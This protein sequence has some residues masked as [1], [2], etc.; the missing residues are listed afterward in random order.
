MINRQSRE[1]IVARL[2]P[3]SGAGIWE[4]GP[5]LGALTQLLVDSGASVRL[6][7]VD[8]GFIGCLEEIFQNEIAEQRVA[9]VAGDARKTMF[10]ESKSPD[11]IVGNLPY[12]VGSGLIVKLILAGLFSLPM[13][14]TLQKEVVERMISRP[15]SPGYGSFS[16]LCQACCKVEK[17]LVLPPGDFYPAPEV[18]SAVVRL[19]PMSGKDQPFIKEKSAHVILDSLLRVVFTS[20]RKTLN[21]NIARNACAHGLDPRALYSALEKRQISANRRAESLS[22]QDYCQLVSDVMGA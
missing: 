4:I 8:R 19:N 14:F 12:N 15:G 3:L 22:V 16:I 20:R 18:S 9:I 21:N 5:G 7:E 6:F 13:V 11:A 1:Y 2:P 10:A 17:L